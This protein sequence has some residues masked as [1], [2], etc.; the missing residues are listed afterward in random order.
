MYFNIPIH[1]F[2]IRGVG[3]G[4]KIYFIINISRTIKIL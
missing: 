2:I 3:I 4:K 1:L